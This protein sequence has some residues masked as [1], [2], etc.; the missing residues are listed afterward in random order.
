MKRKTGSFIGLFAAAILL[1]L[2]SSPAARAQNGDWDLALDLFEA[3]DW[4]AA[5]RESRRAALAAPQNWEARILNAVSAL[6]LDKDRQAS[7]ATLM[8]AVTD[9]SASTEMR[10]LA[11]YE[12]GRA[13]WR[14]GNIAEAYDLLVYAYRNTEENSLFL[15]TGCT[16][17]LIMREYPELE[18]QSQSLTMQ[19]QSSRRLFDWTLQQE[20]MLRDENGTGFLSKP[21]EWI[22]GLYSSQVAPAI[23]MRCSCVPSCSE[24]FLRACRKHG[25]L[26]FPIQADRFFR[27]PSIV[28]NQQNPIVI[29]GKIKYAD[30]LD[31][32]DYWLR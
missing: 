2:P 21:G 13:Q 17:F 6:R 19:L 16:L 25:L 24:Y 20:C 3:G 26:G 23:G 5:W 30:P 18:D 11:A 12:A 8:D 31:A 27:E 28:Q 7:L 10:A 9:S 29:D 32:H 22:V 14:A 4:E 15:R 1:A